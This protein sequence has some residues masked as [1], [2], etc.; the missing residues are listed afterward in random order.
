VKINDKTF[1]HSGLRRKCQSAVEDEL[2]NFEIIFNGIND[3]A[4]KSSLLR[5]MSTNFRMRPLRQFHAIDQTEVVFG[6]E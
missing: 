5:V 2:L 6:V 4:E 3:S 1:S